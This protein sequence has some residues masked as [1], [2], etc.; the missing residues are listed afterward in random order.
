M[1]ESIYIKIAPLIGITVLMISG[2]II[3]GLIIKIL[4][5]TFDGCL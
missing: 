5:W 1:K 2:V 3:W 4:I